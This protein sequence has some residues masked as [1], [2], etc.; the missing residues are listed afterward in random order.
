VLRKKS[1]QSQILAVEARD[2]DRWCRILAAE[3]LF[4]RKQL[5]FYVERQVK[6]RRADDATRITLVADRVVENLCMAKCKS[7]SIS[8]ISRGEPFQAISVPPASRSHVTLGRNEPVRQ[9]R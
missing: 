4:L 9:P 7:L 1:I 3:N 6:P 8:W 5:A 2:G